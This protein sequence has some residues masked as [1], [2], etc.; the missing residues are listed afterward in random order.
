VLVAGDQPWYKPRPVALARLPPTPVT[1]ARK[2]NFVMPKVLLALT[3]HGQ[4][5]DTGRTTGFYVPEAAHP[6]RVLTAAGY[7]VDFVSVDG[8]APPTDGVKPGDEEL[9]RF[10]ADQADR[11]S[12]TPRP[13]QLDSSD[14][15]AVLF[16]GGHGTMWDFPESTELANLATSVYD[17]GG[18]V[19]AVCHGPAGL[20]NLRT[21]DGSYLVD[22]KLVTSFTNAEEDAVGLSAAVPFLLESKL[23]ERGAR[24]IGGAN[25]AAN[26]V[27]DR[28]LVTGQ[29]P[30]SAVRVA[31]LMI[32]ELEQA[33]LGTN[34]TSSADGR[35]SAAQTSALYLL[36]ESVSYLYAAALRSVAQLGVADHLAAGPRTAEE[37]AAATGTQADLMYR[38][39]RLLAAR[40]IVGEEAGRFYLTAQGYALRSDAEVSV[41]D[42]ILMTAAD[43]HWQSAGALTGVLRDG[44]P[45]F[46]T[47]FGGSYY[48]HIKGGE[49][50]EVF[51]RGMGAF[52]AAVDRVA[53]QSYDFPATGT[54]VDVGGGVGGLLAQVLAERPALNGVLFDAEDVLAKHDLGGVDPARWRLAPGDFFTEVPAGGD[55]YVLKRILHNWSDSE[56]VQ[57]LRNCR[58]AMAPGGR[59][60][61]IDPVVRPG[62]G[63]DAAKMY[64]LIMMVL[65]SGRERTQAEFVDLLAQA[66][67]RVTQVIH[68]EAPVSVIE[69]VA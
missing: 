30:A 5:G 41:R 11:L 61:V 20:V 6:H 53:V 29:N 9:T 35:L 22:G 16:V 57:I 58:R 43:S 3:S 12:T 62:F 39:L 26:A 1:S 56:C 54:L 37:L 47:L 42:A 10:L 25:F 13:D 14:Y 59:I 45:A 49:A 52:S 48:T 66:G 55:V 36:D 60:V 27:A 31:E 7:E 18:V 17:R 34:G 33:G 28:R 51:N 44:R 69:A 8:G 65:L 4:L 32:E 68:T 67:L 64:D 50:G 15:V 23:V 40:R 2:G 38:T 46:E 24:F 19:G 21:G 63:P